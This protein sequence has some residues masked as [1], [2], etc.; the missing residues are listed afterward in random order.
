MLLGSC[1]PAFCRQAVAGAMESTSVPSEDVRRWQAKACLSTAELQF[2]P[3]ILLLH[4]WE[5]KCW[6]LCTLSRDITAGIRAPGIVQRG[7][8]PRSC[9]PCWL[10]NG[11]LASCCS[12][13]CLKS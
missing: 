2:V 8:C 4:V 13:C 10:R 9:G 1:S 6:Q 5:G 11:A 12:A 3:P 7:C